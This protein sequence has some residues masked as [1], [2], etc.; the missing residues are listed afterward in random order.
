MA[1]GPNAEVAANNKISGFV[2][3]EV[4]EK[5]KIHLVGYLH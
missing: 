3:E 4:S 1:A 5:T 2:S